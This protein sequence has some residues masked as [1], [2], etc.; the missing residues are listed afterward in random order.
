MARIKSKVTSDGSLS[1][2]K[3]LPLTY[4]PLPAGFYTAIVR[5]VKEESYRAGAGEHSNPDSADGKWDYLK[6]RP[7]LHIVHNGAVHAITRHDLTIGVINSEGELVRPDGNTKENPVWSGRNGARYFLKELGFFVA[8]LDAD[9]EETGSYELLFDAD[10]ISNMVLRVGIGYE[11]YSKNHR[12]HNMDFDQFKQWLSDRGIAF[13][14]SLET[15]YDTINNFND[16]NGYV[17]SDDKLTLKSVPVGWYAM[18]SEQAEAEGFYHEAETRRTY[19][20]EEAA[21]IANTLLQG[22]WDTNDIAF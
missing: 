8:E 1:P 10:A 18:T 2:S 5:S 6:I 4:A 17:E 3:S 7:T 16:E 20:N 14:A 19:T 22:N 9:G 21:R 12:E 11:V 15:I 13:N